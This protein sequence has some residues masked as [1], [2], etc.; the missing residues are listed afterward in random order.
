MTRTAEATGLG[1]TA[2]VAVEQHFPPGQRILVDELA[3]QMLPFG[4]R[5]LLAA[6]ALP[7]ARD[8]L[9]RLVDKTFPG[10]W[11]GVICR[12][13]HIDEALSTA[14]D[15]FGAMLNL[16]A[17]WDT[18]AYR[19]PALAHIPVWEFDQRR[20][21]AA[22]QARLRELFGRTRAHVTQAAFD[23]DEEGLGP[24]LAALGY[25]A[26]V[27]T[28]FVM[29]AL[30]QYLTIAAVT[31]LLQVMSNAVPGSRAIFTYIREDFI[32]G[33]DLAGQARLYDRYVR[34]GVWRF[35]LAP[36]RVGDWLRAY[37]WR[38]VEDVSYEELGRSYLAPTGRTLATMTV[39]RLVQ[40]EK[41]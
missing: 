27:R 41:Q 40:A 31:R 35:G 7:W 19:L 10:L 2:L 9:V 38:L 11:A 15:Q 26:K 21:I 4:G 1:P 14:D 29:E 33:R 8:G 18:R 32:E 24:A 6:T 13:R 20:T 3:G 39:E 17:G 5:A 12:K 16:G 30:T 37:G 25:D 34:A 23:F 22:K 36:D 28:V